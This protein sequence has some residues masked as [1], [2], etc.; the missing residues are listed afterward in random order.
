MTAPKTHPLPP[1]KVELVPA[2]RR[3]SGKVITA[4]LDRARSEWLEK[5]GRFLTDDEIRAELAR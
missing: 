5:N 1:P 3:V 4:L 2:R